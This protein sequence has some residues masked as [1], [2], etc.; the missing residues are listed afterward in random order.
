MVEKMN[1]QDKSTFNDM[2]D[3]LPLDKYQNRYVNLWRVLA[4]QH[5]FYDFYRNKYYDD[6]P[7]FQPAGD[8]EPQCGY[9][10]CFNVDDLPCNTNV[11]CQFDITYD[12]YSTV[13]GVFE[14]FTARYSYAE[15]V[16]L[17]EYFH[18]R[19]LRTDILFKCYG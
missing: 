16:Y 8:G 6:L 4:Y 1:P 2:I 14:D 17:C 18:G 9:I 19:V 12:S 10:D 3:H 13:T 15:I 5:I 7:F 11:D